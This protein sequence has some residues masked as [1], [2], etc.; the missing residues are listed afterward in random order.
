MQYFIFIF[1]DQQKGKEKETEEAKRGIKEETKLSETRT[2]TEKHQK[3]TKSPVEKDKVTT[4]RTATK[5][6]SSE[7]K[8]KPSK[9]DEKPA[10][11]IKT[12]Q[13]K[14]VSKPVVITKQKDEEY[15]SELLETVESSM[16]FLI[17]HQN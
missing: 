4:K 13:K 15:V 11:E 16:L 5:R 14:E 7:S 8:H 1:K 3:A 17:K 9:E 12:D 6:K 2:P 10:P